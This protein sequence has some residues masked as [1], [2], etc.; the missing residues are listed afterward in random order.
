MG[1]DATRST[2]LLIDDLA[3]PE[4][5]RWRAG[6]LWFSDMHDGVVKTVTPSGESE[7]IVRVPG[8]PSG[9][10]WDPAGRL[11]VVSMED[12]RIVRL[13]VNGNLSTVADLSKHSPFRLNDM[14]VDAQGRAFVGTFG[15]DIY[16]GQRMGPSAVLAVAPDGTVS[17][18]ADDL[19]C[20]NGMALRADSATLVVAETFGGRL[21]EFDLGSGRRRVVAELGRSC[22]DGICLD[23]EGAVW[24]ALVRDQEVVRID[25]LGVVVDRIGTPGR[26][27][28]SCALGGPDGQTLFVCTC[29]VVPGRGLMR[30]DEARAARIGR[31]EH[32]RVEVAGN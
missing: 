1:P 4:G 31:I 15:S 12:R 11:L 8:S 17:V 14:L 26:T 29:R 25:Q 20:P 2:E 30:P 18:V 32:V 16:A 21:I 28:V 13:D 27:P 24:V 3:F 6:R 10:G 9:L 5:P 22:P 19:L 23:G 7:V